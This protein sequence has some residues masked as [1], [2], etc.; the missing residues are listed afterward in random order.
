VPNT[1]T[2]PKA[3]KRR[4][5][6]P[7]PPPPPEAA[8]HRDA[9]LYAAGT[10]ESPF[11]KE[12]LVVASWKLFQNR[13]GLQGYLDQ[14]PDANRVMSYVYGSRGLVSLGRLESVGDGVFNLIAHKPS[15]RRPVV[16]PA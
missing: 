10:L 1:A 16:L 13:F 15:P 14:Y 5:P 2:P 12:E 6:R 3:P 11:T 8:N 9:I 4:Q 7:S